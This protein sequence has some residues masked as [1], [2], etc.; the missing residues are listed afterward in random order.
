MFPYLWDMFIYSWDGW[1]YNTAYF[2]M[3]DNPLA[4]AV[5]FS[6]ALGVASRLISMYVSITVGRRASAERKED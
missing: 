3:V 1:L 6:M 2:V 5:T 4:T